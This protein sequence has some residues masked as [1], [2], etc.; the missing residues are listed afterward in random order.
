MAGLLNRRGRFGRFAIDSLKPLPPPKRVRGTCLARCPGPSDL[1]KRS[2]RCALPS[3]P[4]APCA[5]APRMASDAEQ[6]EEE[7]C[8][9]EAIYGDDAAVA[10]EVPRTVEVRRRRHRRRPPLPAAPRT[11]SAH[12]HSRKRPTRLPPLSPAARDPEPRRG[13]GRARAR[14][15]AAR[16]PQRIAAGDRGRCTP[17]A[18]RINRRGRRP[19]RR[20]VRARCDAFA[21]AATSV[22]LQLWCA[23]LGLYPC[24][25]RC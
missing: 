13:A 22:L 14:D 4:S 9:I 12:L 16:L 15:A 11:Q 10:R 18:T 23:A 24:N 1:A 25:Q 7:L 21:R 3:A 2:A 6:Q 20:D 19:A 17:P 5:V 8:S